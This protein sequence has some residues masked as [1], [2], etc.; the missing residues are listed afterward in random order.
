MRKENTKQKEIIHLVDPEPC[1]TK[2]QKQSFEFSNLKMCQLHQLG[3]QF[4][5]KSTMSSLNIY[6]TFYKNIKLYSK[7][8]KHTSFSTP[9]RNS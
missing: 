9:V 3:I 7:S 8:L 1:R 2:Q 4:S 6:F 5:I